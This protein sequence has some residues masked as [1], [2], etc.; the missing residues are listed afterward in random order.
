[1]NYCIYSVVNWHETDSPF[2]MVPCVQKMVARKCKKYGKHEYELSQ[3]LLS[4]LG[5]ILALFSSLV[6]WVG[7]C[8]CVSVCVCVCVCV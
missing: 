2:E 3:N 8:E 4:F 5:E 6:V 1:M 7:V